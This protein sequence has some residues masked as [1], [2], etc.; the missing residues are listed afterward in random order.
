MHTH[1]QG[2]TTNPQPTT[3]T[4]PAQAT[5]PM[6]CPVKIGD[7]LANRGD[8]GSSTVQLT[9]SG[10]VAAIK[11]AAAENP[12]LADWVAEKIGAGKGPTSFCQLA[13]VLGLEQRDTMIVMAAVHV[14]DPARFKLRHAP[15]GMPA[16]PEGIMKVFKE[17]FME[18]SLAAMFPVME[19]VAQK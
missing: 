2:T 15:E 12:A 10:S 5:G 11:V 17:A 1:T 18:S 3:A 7:L 8:P 6:R 9:A 13:P 14:G 19:V 16:N 4:D